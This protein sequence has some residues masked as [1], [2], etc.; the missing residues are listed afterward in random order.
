[1]ALVVVSGFLLL[2]QIPVLA[3]IIPGPIQRLVDRKAIWSDPWNNQVYGGDQVANGIWAISTGGITG[4]GAGE[5]F[6]KTIPEAHTDMILPAIG[7]ELGWAGIACIFIL[8]LVF[9][10]RSIIIGR[11]AGAPF[12]FYVCA[13][14]GIGIFVQF[15]LDCR[16][17]YRERFHCL[18]WLY[19]LPVM[20]ARHYYA[21]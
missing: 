18:A 3:K 21:A 15:L 9:L 2:D 6:A 10:H 8:F 1:M 17:F 5:G 19:H 11:Q 14:A 7:E 16:W 20:A 12:L 4:Q 13:G